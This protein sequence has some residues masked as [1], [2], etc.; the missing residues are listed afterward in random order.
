LSLTVRTA[1][2]PNNRRWLEWPAQQVEIGMRKSIALLIAGG[3]LACLG[4][5]A[6]VEPEE[7]ATSTAAVDEGDNGGSTT[8]CSG[9][10]PTYDLDRAYDPNV[11]LLGCPFCLTVG[12]Q[13][14]QLQRW[15]SSG[16]DYCVAQA[17]C[18]VG[19]RYQM[20]RLYDP[21]NQCLNQPCIVTGGTRE[22]WAG[23]MQSKCPGIPATCGYLFC[24]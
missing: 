12:G 19:G 4:C 9:A 16:Y 7:V 15:D 1:A 2:N 17:F 24:I 14:G 10:A 18:H 11:Q 23:T 22:G 13:L 5:S 6:A 8:S 21:A 20:N 3:T